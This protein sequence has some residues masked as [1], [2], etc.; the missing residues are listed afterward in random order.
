MVFGVFSLARG[1]DFAGVGVL[2]LVV[3]SVRERTGA[4]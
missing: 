3:C 2:L 4:G 1:V